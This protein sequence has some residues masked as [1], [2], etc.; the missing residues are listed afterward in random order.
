MVNQIVEPGELMAR[1]VECAQKLGQAP[2][3]ALTSTKAL[4]N[5]AVFAD[6]ESVL[7]NE[8]L[9]MSDLSDSPDFAEGV[10][11]F[12]EKRKPNFT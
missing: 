11:A 8:R 12:F 3:G 1:A 5:Q 2:A 6:L 10:K 9:E 7:E 4:L